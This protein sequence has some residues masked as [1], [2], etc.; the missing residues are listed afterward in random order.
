M[1]FFSEEIPL[2]PDN[3]HP[4]PFAHQAHDGVFNNSELSPTTNMVIPVLKL[5][6]SELKNTS[7]IYHC[8]LDNEL[9]NIY[10]YSTQTGIPWSK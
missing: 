4:I 6:Q 8:T 5:E 3:R 9:G 1:G 10:Y 7:I 2:L